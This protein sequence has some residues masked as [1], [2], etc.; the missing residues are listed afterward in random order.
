MDNNAQDMIR[1][2]G[3]RWSS[4]KSKGNSTN[5]I[6]KRRFIIPGEVYLSEF[7]L[8]SMAVTRMAQ[9]ATEVWLFG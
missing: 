8:N 9:P 4:S 2:C 1:G 5:W 6:S 3:K 7:P